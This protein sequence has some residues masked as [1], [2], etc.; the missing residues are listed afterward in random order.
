MGM[1]RSGLLVALM[2]S[3]ALV[4]SGCGT[5]TGIPGHGGGK[6]FVEEQRLVSASIRGSLEAIDVSSLR[7]K[8]VAM[9]F[10]IIADEGAGNMVGGRASLG[11]I[12]TGGTMVSPVTTR[13]NALEVYQLAGAGTSQ[14]NTISAGSGTNTSSVEIAG[15]NS[16]TSTQVTAGPTVTNSSNTQ[17][18]SGGTATHTTVTPQTTTTTENPQLN[19]E[20]TTT[21]EANQITSTT[22]T[23][24]TTTNQTVNNPPTVTGVES[25]TE[26]NTVTTTNSGGTTTTTMVTPETTVEVEGISSTTNPN[27]TTTTNGNNQSTQD[28]NGSNTSN[29]ETNATGSTTSIQ[30]QVQVRGYTEQTRGYQENVQAQLQYRGLGDYQVL[31]VPK[32]DASLLMSLTR[33]YF[34]LN[35]IHVTTPQ[36]PT[37]EAIVYV[38][39][40]IFGTDRKRTDL[41]IYNNERLSAETSIEMF[42]ADRSGKIIMRP[43]VGNVRTDY[44]EDYIVWAGPFDTQRKTSAGL[45][46]MNDF[47]D[48]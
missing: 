33:N 42:A 1:K 34:I 14:A 35:G 44:R 38:T 36:D 7:G 41:I 12:L 32:S 47:T 22:V 18:N 16:A 25:S 5:L 8:R 11:A 48:Q 31:S 19:S 4:L 40:D 26:A 17:T 24:G 15:T 46:P 39:V 13:T 29:S 20:A 9:I 23:G 37:A 21:T 10:S 27:V 43:S 28:T 6:R 2:A 45:G 30:E 3:S